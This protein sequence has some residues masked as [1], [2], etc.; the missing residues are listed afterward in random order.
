M[1]ARDFLKKMYKIA[2]SALSRDVGDAFMA[3][4]CDLYSKENSN[5]LEEADRLYNEL[6]PAA[7][8]LC[9]VILSMIQEEEE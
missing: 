8:V 6:S 2:D 3:A 1:T 4:S 7:N 5:Y 9:A